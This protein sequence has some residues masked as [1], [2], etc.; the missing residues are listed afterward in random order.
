M[1][2]NSSLIFMSCAL[3]CAALFSQ[4]YYLLEKPAQDLTEKEQVLVEI[5]MHDTLKDSDFTK[6]SSD[7]GVYE[8][9]F[10]EAYKAYLKSVGHGRITR[11]KHKAALTE[12]ANVL[13]NFLHPDLVTPS[14]EEASET[15]TV[16]EPAEYDDNLVSLLIGIDYKG[17]S[18][19]LE[20]CI[21]DIEHVM[22]LFLKPKLNVKPLEM[23]VMSDHQKGSSLYPTRSN[24]LSQFDAFVKRANKSKQGYFHYSGHGSYM[25]DYNGDELDKRDE[26]LC[27]IDGDY[28]GFIED[29]LV[30]EHLVKSLD[31][32]VKLTA[33]TDCCHSG[34]IMDLP[35]KWTADGDYV[36]ENRLSNAEL[37][38][39]PNVVMLSGCKDK[40]TSSD[41]GQIEGTSKGSGALTGAF[42]ETLREYNF[43]ITYRQLL[44]RIRERLKNDGFDQVPQLSTTY[45]IDLDDYFMKKEPVLRP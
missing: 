29:D 10:E 35:Y 41:G 2:R 23:I 4:E 32:D 21:H 44:T 39:L 14:G 13:F 27:P 18:Y 16:A 45:L 1:K 9:K 7:D 26:A 40:Q 36:F 38:K 34:T 3:T 6:V 24:I 11:R 25:K 30:F 19:E 43:E 15:T 42:L 33:V 28:E 12:A 20:N 5:L 17:S 31:K 22:D 37:A 8:E